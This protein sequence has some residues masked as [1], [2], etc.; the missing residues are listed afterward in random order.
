MNDSPARV[1]LMTSDDLAYDT[2]PTTTTTTTTLFRSNTTTP[3]SRTPFSTSGSALTVTHP[4]TYTRLRLWL[5]SLLR[6]RIKPSEVVVA[7]GV[8]Q[9]LLKHDHLI[10]SVLCKPAL[11]GTRLSDSALTEASPY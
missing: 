9:P 6:A 5:T 1:W 11:T 7:R 4:S 3:F 8:N 2:T 10:E